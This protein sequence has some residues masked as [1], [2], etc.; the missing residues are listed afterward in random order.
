[1]IV[2]FYYVVSTVINLT[3]FSDFALKADIFQSELMKYLQCELPGHDPLNPCDRSA[4][5]PIVSDALIVLSYGFHGMLPV[6]NL[7][8]TIS[9]QDLKIKCQVICGKI[10]NLSTSNMKNTASSTLESR[11]MSWI[12]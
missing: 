1:M 2:F 12:S 11:E 3:G 7:I 6:V 5:E 8:F 9:I 10:K 4:F